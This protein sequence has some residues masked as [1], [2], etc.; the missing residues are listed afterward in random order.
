MISVCITTYCGEKYIKEQIESILVQLGIDDEIIISDDGSSDN[1]LPIIKSFNDTRIKIFNFKRNKKGF[2][3]SE[4]VSSNFENAIKHAKGD[5]IF[6]ADQDDVWSASKVEKM[7]FYFQEKECDVIVSNANLIID[8]KI[9]SNAFW[10][11]D[12][13]PIHNYILRRG[14][15]HGCCMAFRRSLLQYIL[16]FPTE[17]P[18]HDSWI[19]LIGELLGKAYFIDEPLTFYRLHG[20]NTSR[21]IDNTLLYKI[22]YRLKLLFQIYC[23]VLKFKI[24]Y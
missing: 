18:L 17:L 1:T 11:T 5:Y 3:T 19:G 14:K 8:E 6:L 21:G 20:N 12:R 24:L 22:T 2:R 23:R 16:P 9:D 13:K 15:Y 4:I 7:L 10:Y